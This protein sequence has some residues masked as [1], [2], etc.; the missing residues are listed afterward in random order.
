MEEDRLSNIES[1]LTFM[2]T[3][4]KANGNSILS[5]DKTTNDDCPSQIPASEATGDEDSST[6]PTDRH[7]VRS[8]L[9]LT[10]R[11][12]GPC[13]LFALCNELS[14]DLLSEQK[15][16]GQDNAKDEA[17]RGKNNNSRLPLN[18]TAKNILERTC[19]E[20]GLEEPVD[21]DTEPSSIRL[22][23]KQFLLMT[24]SQF[25]QQAE[26]ATDIFVP[27][28]FWS[29]VERV[30]SKPLAP[31]DEAW[32]ICFN[33]IILLVLGPENSTQD[34]DSLL[35]SHFLQ[36][37]LMTVRAALSNPR[38]LMAPKIINV[39]ALAL[40]SIAA[41]IYFPLGLAESV[42]AQACVLAR[43]MGLHQVRSAPEGVTPEEAQERF[44]VF[45]SL[46]L[47]DKSVSIS[48]GL[49]C[50]LP[51]FDCSLSSE[52]GEAGSAESKFAARTELAKLEDESYRLFHSVDAPKKTSARY[53]SALLRIEQGLEYWANANGMFN[54]PYSSTRDVDLQ[55]EFLAARICVFRKS[56]ELNHVR[57]ALSD[58]RASCLWI[59][60]SYG[61]H[62][63]SMI[64]QLDEILLS[65][66]QTKSLGKRTSGRS[67]KS[68]RTN[69]TES[70][71]EAR[72]E[73]GPSRF[74]SL[75]DKFSV[76]GFFLLASNVIK[77]SSAYD[78]SKTDED[79]D[80]LQR[81]SICY[82]EM[83]ARIQANNHTHKVGRAFE[84][85]L[86]VIRLVK[87]CPPP[88]SSSLGFQQLNNVVHNTPSFSNPF[89][90]Q[91]YNTLPSPS[92]SSLPAIPWENFTTKSSSNALDSPS[93][94][95]S[96]GLLTP[97]ESQ[98]FQA[99]DPL[100][101]NI[102]FPQTQHQIRT[103]SFSRHQTNESDVCMDDFADGKLLSEFLASNPG[104]PFD[105]AP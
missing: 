58:A 27:S 95:A 76:P 71:K 51:S 80:L 53:R 57:R 20:A 11:Y 15:A 30:Y 83:D 19:L 90:E 6:I 54:S 59:I 31:A 55:L 73:N 63:P 62:E 98:P 66:S 39:Q 52:L 47:R 61:K 86:E 10:D 24:Q 40:L 78:E 1:E 36:P 89:G 96:P 104:M 16:Q 81:I 56:P 9:N 92:A 41:S 12:H 105:I 93:A 46:Y 100:R 38:V 43:T 26:Y 21:L 17:K 49:I 18:D 25:F 33:T 22:P 91:H 29:N 72:S 3:L 14:D 50:W 82:K 42:F 60:V 34:C 32:A 85:L 44:K 88:E 2:N 64:N 69:S 35:G 4:L 101:Q 75:L 13:T 45:R 79:L 84:N 68:S 65:K 7:V 74:H 67:N 87:N 37:F 94:G 97:M 103:P 77:P 8:S 28:C 70:V 102:F 23:P 48:R 99:F 5:I